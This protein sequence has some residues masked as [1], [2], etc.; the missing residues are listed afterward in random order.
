[1]PGHDHFNKLEWMYIH[2]APINRFYNPKIKISEGAASITINSDPK[3]F[4]AANA[5]HG[6]VYFK[7][8][9]DAAFFAV[10]SLVDDAFVLTTNFTINL[11]RPVVFGELRAEGTVVFNARK[12][13]IAEAKLYNHKDKLIATGSGTFVKSDIAL[14]EDVG[15]KD[16][17][18]DR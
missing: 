6:S 4:H 3:Y 2:E 7:M 14:N 9:D 18:L 10:N 16:D 17:S 5:V 12:S 13:F 15:Y 11:L 1:M 8:L